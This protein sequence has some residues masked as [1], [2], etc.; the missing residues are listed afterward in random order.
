MRSRYFAY[1]SNLDPEQMLAR[2]TSAVALGRARLAGWSFACNKL[3]SDGTAKANL[4][5][6][7]GGSVWGVVYE[8]DTLHLADL[9][10]H[11]GGYERLE[12]EVLLDDGRGQRAHVYVSERLAPEPVLLE[13][14]KARILAGARA[15]GLPEDWLRSLELLPSLPGPARSRS[16]RV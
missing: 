8:V 9:D 12:L 11:E 14:Y 10:R 13:A 3:G 2:V 5:R 4:V 15:H 1:G 16:G 7:A 6:A